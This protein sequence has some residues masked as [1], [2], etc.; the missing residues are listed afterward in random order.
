M[1]THS[2]QRE[3]VFGD[4]LDALVVNRLAF[5]QVQPLQ[6]KTRVGEPAQNLRVDTRTSTKVHGVQLGHAIDEPSECRR[7]DIVGIGDCQPLETGTVLKAF[8]ER[9]GDGIT[10]C[11]EVEPANGPSVSKGAGRGFEHSSEVGQ[12][13]HRVNVWVLP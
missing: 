6:L 8:D 11:T 7:A 13:S 12:L 2:S 1:V 5:T 4:C 9:I 3:P 10:Q